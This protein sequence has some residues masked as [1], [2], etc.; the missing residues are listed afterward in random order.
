MKK[1]KFLV[2]L[3]H[4][5]S[6]GIFY[7]LILLLTFNIALELFTEKGEIGNFS[8]GSHYSK[9]YQFPV[10]LSVQPQK[11][12]FNNYIYEAKSKGTNIKD[13]NYSG[14]TMHYARPITSRDSLE[15]NSVVSV[16]NKGMKD[17][18]DI[19]NSRFSGDGYV[20]IKP[21]LLTHKFLLIFR[22]YAD[23][24]LLILVFF[25]LKSIF[26]SLRRNFGFSSRLYRYIL[27]IGIA[28][29]AQ[30]FLVTVSDFIL[31]QSLSL[32]WI[33]P[34]FNHPGFVNLTINPRIDFNFTIL[35]IGIALMVLGKLFKV[36]T[37]LKEE[38]E[39][40]I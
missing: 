5:L 37:E 3:L 35:F 29:I 17:I 6:L 30:V 36:G 4:R 20:T 34:L 13:Q 11:P 27:F 38:N 16:H 10:S 7:L 18:Y 12:M 2:H 8:S 22:T 24:I 19:S 33:K 25:F 14:G 31:A 9:G 23:F 1:Q 26:A 39:L 15:Y 32:I 21:S 40:T 28:L